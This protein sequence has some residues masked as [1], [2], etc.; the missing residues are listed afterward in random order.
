MHY[1]VPFACYADEK[2]G[3]FLHKRYLIQNKWKHNSSIFN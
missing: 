3:G 1:N 2:Q